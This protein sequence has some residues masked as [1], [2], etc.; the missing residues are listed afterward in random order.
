MRSHVASSGRGQ[1]T[2][3]LFSKSTATE[4]LLSLQEKEQFRDSQ[5]G[6]AAVVETNSLAFRTMV[7]LATFSQSTLSGTCHTT[8]T[9]H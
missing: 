1:L 5:L 8:G 2:N 4:K 7:G 9:A 3:G 6:Q